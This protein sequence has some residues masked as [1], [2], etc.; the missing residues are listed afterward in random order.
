MVRA[1]IVVAALVVG[2]I[3]C[4]ALGFAG[5]GEEAANSL[6]FAA[7]AMALLALFML[8]LRLPLR[9]RGSRL[10]AW[11]S[12]ALV[13]AA[14]V[15]VVVT[16]NIALYRH[17][18]HFDVSREGRNTPPAQFAAVIEHLRSPLSLT[19]FYNSADGNALAARDLIAIAARG[20]PLF[21]FRAI[22]LD[23]EPGL[24]RDVGVH[25]YNTALFQ[26]GER[27]VTVE[28]N[29]D[30]TRLAYAAMRALKERV[31]TVCFITG[32]GETFRPT[33]PHFHYSHVE[34]LQG[35]DVPGAGDVLVAEPADLERLQI[36]LT[37]IGYETRGIVT[38]A[39]GAIP[40]DCAVLAEVGP[41]TAFAA[42]EADLLAQYLTAGGRLL[43]LLDPVFTVDADFKDHVLGPLGLTTPQAIV[44][45]PLNHFRTDPDKV[46]VPYYPP[47]PIT[48]RVA[49][50]VFP[51]ARPIE[52]APPPA[53]VTTSILASSSEDG[54]RRP[55]TSAGNGELA[56]AEGGAAAGQDKGA[57]ALAVAVTGIWPGA[58]TDKHF[59]LVLAGTSK[60]ATNEYFPYVSNGELAV[61]M[62]RWLAADETMPSVAP[63]TYSVSEIVLTSRQMRDVF[64]VLE[65]LLPL[66]TLMCGVLVWWRRR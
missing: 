64:I 44:I 62:L 46:A 39:A 2:A 24:A 56:V 54:Y 38:A 43:L 22:D 14:A 37:E 18:V 40:A 20:H 48:E 35:H 9:G 57:Q 21:T 66:S 36:A 58:Q 33:P 4:G 65:V 55:V 25:A 8:A 28:N 1:N 13:T 45:D 19:Y 3:A 63:Q 31:E 29:A 17:D 42:G 59:R 27:R 10:S 49:L 30:V 5:F 34:T 6:L 11:I 60:F 52:V 47:H 15:A 16:A 41:R 51:Q 61:A 26:A 50:T 53:G 23:K 32:H 12:T 7:W